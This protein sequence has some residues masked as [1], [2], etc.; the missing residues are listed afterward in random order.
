MSYQCA[1]CHKK[2]MRG[3]LVSHSKQRTHRLYRVNLHT[4]Q[5]AVSGMAKRMKVCTTC[6]RTLKKNAKLTRP[7]IVLKEVSP[8]VEIKPV[9]KPMPEV[10]VKETTAKQKD[11]KVK[12]MTIEELM[13]E[14]ASEVK[15]KEKEVK[16]VAKK[17]KVVKKT[18]KVIK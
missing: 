15:V 12:T 8:K 5:A 14:S 6:L 10:T 16:P 13:K 11:V 1:I 4:I 3:N 17:V 9:V 18:S 7:Q 2:S